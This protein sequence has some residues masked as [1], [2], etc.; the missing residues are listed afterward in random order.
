MT[1]ENLPLR[2]FGAFVWCL[3]ITAGVTHYGH[4]S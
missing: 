2:L 3:A 1:L 4:Q